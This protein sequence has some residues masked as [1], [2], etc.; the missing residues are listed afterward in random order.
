MRSYKKIKKYVGGSL[1]KNNKGLL[2]INLSDISMG[3]SISFTCTIQNPDGSTSNLV[4]IL[5]PVLNSGT[6]LPYSPPA[7]NS[8][9][10]IPFNVVGITSGNINQANIYELF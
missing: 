5:Y 9:S 8:W 2:L 1:S 3:T 10:I 7:G 6:G 4:S